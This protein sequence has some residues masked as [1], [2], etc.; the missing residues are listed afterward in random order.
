MP[1]RTKPFFQNAIQGLMFVTAM[2]KVFLG[3]IILVAGAFTPVHPYFLAYATVFTALLLLGSGGLQLYGGLKRGDRGGSTN[4]AVV[5]AVDIFVLMFMIALFALLLG[6]RHDD[7]HRQRAAKREEHNYNT[8]LVYALG[9]ICAP[10]PVFIWLTTEAFY[11]YGGSLRQDK[12]GGGNEL[13]RG[14]SEDNDNS[15]LP[16]T[17]EL[18]PL[19]DDNDNDDDDALNDVS[20]G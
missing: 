4:L 20:T 2:Y 6:A 10:Y 3:L 11:L 13:K 15:D 14:L 16:V 19:D 5:I 12:E 9:F 18:N 8:V 17:K 1:L 7:V